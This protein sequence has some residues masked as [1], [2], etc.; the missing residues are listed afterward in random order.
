MGS[1]GEV[2]GASERNSLKADRSCAVSFFLASLATP[3]TTSLS[4][5]PRKLEEVVTSDSHAN[6]FVRFEVISDYVTS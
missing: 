3:T 4:K 1:L 5:S 2:P 6:A